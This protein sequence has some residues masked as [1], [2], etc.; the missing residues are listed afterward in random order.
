MDGPSE[1][2]VYIRIELL[3][4]RLHNYCDVVINRVATA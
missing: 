2:R 4:G 3:Q 1:D